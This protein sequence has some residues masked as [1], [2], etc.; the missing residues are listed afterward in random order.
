MPHL[1]I[2]PRAERGLLRCRRFLASKNLL[3]ATRAAAEIEHSF[4]LLMTMPEIG[5]P[6][7]DEPR[8]REL[9]I[10]FGDSGYLAQY[11]YD[12]QRDLVIVTA[13]R[14]QLEASY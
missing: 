2:S 4:S 1:S 14:H 8:L 13:F 7:N 5:R 10:P 11:S 9:V 3:A 6:Y 12:K